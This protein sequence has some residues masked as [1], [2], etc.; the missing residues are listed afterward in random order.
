MLSKPSEATVVCALFTWM[1]AG[2]CLYSFTQ[3][4]G[5]YCRPEAVITRKKITLLQTE[6]LKE[7]SCQS[8]SYLMTGLL[9]YCVLREG[10]LQMCWLFFP[11]EL[12]FYY[13][14][15]KCTYTFL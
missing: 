14:C 3:S 13:N 15:H 11:L 8:N 9:N 2:C 5:I 7:N 12:L 6:L 4:S 1:M 10:D